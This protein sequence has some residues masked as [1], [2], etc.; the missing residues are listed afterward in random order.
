[1]LQLNLN[2]IKYNNHHRINIQKVELKWKHFTCQK[3]NLKMD[4]FSGNWGEISL[5]W[6]ATTLKIIQK[7]FLDRK[8]LL[9]IHLEIQTDWCKNL[10]TKSYRDMSISDKMLIKRHFGFNVCHCYLI[11][12][13]FGFWCVNIRHQRKLLKVRDTIEF[14]ITNQMETNEVELYF[15]PKKNNYLEFL[16]HNLLCTW[17]LYYWK[18]DAIKQILRTLNW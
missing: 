9:K 13:L 14:N 3:T 11:V 4:E 6:V 2:V 7:L 10:L 15:R 12:Q 16:W 17:I 18:S 5:W 8:L 1:M